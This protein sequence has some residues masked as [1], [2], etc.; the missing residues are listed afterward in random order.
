MKKVKPVNFRW[1]DFLVAGVL[2]GFMMYMCFLRMPSSESRLE[3]TFVFGLWY[4][5]FL[6]IIWF[7]NRHPNIVEDISKGSG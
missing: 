7:L 4:A 6:G 3:V 5:L 1:Y 2:P